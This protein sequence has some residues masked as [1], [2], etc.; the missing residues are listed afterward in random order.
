MTYDIH[1][2]LYIGC[3]YTPVYWG[4]FLKVVEM[5]EVG[6]HYYFSERTNANYREPTIPIE[7]GGPHSSNSSATSLRWGLLL[8][9]EAAIHSMYIASH[10]MPLST[11]ESVDSYGN[12]ML[13]PHCRHHTYS[14]SP[15][16]PRKLAELV[17]TSPNG[18][19]F[20]VECVEHLPHPVRCKVVWEGKCRATIITHQTKAGIGPENR[21]GR[22]SPD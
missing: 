3:S 22:K 14:V 10:I 18:H 19:E 2:R 17:F 21:L 6:V 15:N 9:D 12:C 11:S 8:H 1:N 20:G 16:S 7:G 5:L 4:N 13:H